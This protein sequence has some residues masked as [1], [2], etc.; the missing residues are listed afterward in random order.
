MGRP[1]EE[2]GPPDKRRKMDDKT[3]SDPAPPV[4][5]NIDPLWDDDEMDELLMTQDNLNF[6]DNLTQQASTQAV[7]QCD[8]KGTTNPAQGGLPSDIDN[9][10]CNAYLDGNLTYSEVPAVAAK[11]SY[12]NGQFPVPVAPGLLPGGHSLVNRVS[13]ATVRNGSLTSTA[14]DERTSQVSTKSVKWPSNS[15]IT[16]QDRVTSE[17]RQAKTE[18]DFVVFIDL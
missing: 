11:L 7:P 8:V 3:E 13:S 14:G 2:M 1:D 4:V 10:F 6:I 9:E 18:V 15:I 5:S 12:I 16:E 17:C